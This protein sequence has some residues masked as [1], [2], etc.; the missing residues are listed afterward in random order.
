MAEQVNY[1]RTLA[2]SVGA[3][4]GALF[5]ASG[6]TYYILEHKTTTGYHNAGDSDK[7]IVDQVELGRDSS[8]Q[9]RFD[10]SCETVSRKHAAI[11]KEGDNW[12]IIPLSQTNATYVNSIPVQGEKILNS[13]DEIRLSSRGPVMGFIVPQ[14]ANSLVKSI[15]MTERMNLFRKQALAPYKKGLTFLAILLVL[16]IAGFVAYGIWSNKVM[17]EQGAAIEVQQKNLAALEEEKV[18]LER[19]LMDQRDELDR[20]NEKIIEQEDYVN[21]LQRQI[22]EKEAER[23]AAEAAMAEASAAERAALQAQIDAANEAAEKARKNAAAAVSQLNQSKKA[24]SEQAA[25]IK[26]LENKIKETE[27]A[28]IKV[29]EAAAETVKEAEKATVVKE[30]EPAA[31][32]LFS[33]IEDCYS[34]IYYIKMD[35][36]AVYDRSGKLIYQFDMSDFVGGTGFLLEDGRFVTARRV[37][38]P[39]FYYWSSSIGRD[40]K[41]NIWTLGDLQACVNAG[42]KV[43]GNFTAYSPA[44]T[45]FK[46]STSEMTKSAP[47]VKT[48]IETYKVSRYLRRLVDNTV[49]IYVY[50]SKA[51]ADDW[52]TLGKREQLNVVSGLKFSTPA[53]LAPESGEDVI[54]LG[55][56]FSDG[57]SNSL[58]VNP[59]L[60]KNT[61]NSPDLNDVDVIELATKRFYKG[62][63]GAPVLQNIDGVWT[64][65]GIL[66]HTDGASDR[67]FAAPIANIN[68]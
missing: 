57:F 6:R 52:A 17:T 14:G 33:N 37:I 62:A 22:E 34:A 18:V 23:L 8:C 58:T 13:G 55:Y 51:S 53:S 56:P 11:V 19:G 24:A 35:N 50:D 38:E 16:A 48:I 20:Q 46:F 2:G 7:I 41:G 36:V 68:K 25:A 43:E 28:I 63:D 59:E 4:V 45:S 60:R 26:Q 32:A 15:G 1:K 66:G 5:S 39:W 54:V 3:G 27:T 65:I 49:N 21:D 42:L 9:I 31:D 29:E 64:V 61:I 44:Q 67:D 40:N 12:K 10:E 47:R 30:E